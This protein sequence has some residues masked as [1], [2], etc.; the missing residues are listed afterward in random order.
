VVGGT[1]T[2]KSTLAK[3]LSSYACRDGREVVFV[4]LDIGQGTVCLAFLFR[5]THCMHFWKNG[6][7]DMTSFAHTLA[8]RNDFSTR[9]GSAERH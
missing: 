2:G 7:V 5:T 9:N 1:D 6:C 8:S 4:D 3:I